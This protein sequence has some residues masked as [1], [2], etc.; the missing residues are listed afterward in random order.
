MKKKLNNFTEGSI[1][2]SIIKLSLPVVVSN[3]LQ[4]IYNLIDAFWLGRFSRGAVASISFSFPVLFLLISLGAGL[5][6]AGTILVS[7][8]F[9][10]GERE[11]VNYISTQVFLLV[12]LIS[13]I[14]SVSGIILSPYIL[15]LAGAKGDVFVGSVNYLKICFTGIIFIFGFFVFQSLLRGIGVVQL[16]MFI[17][18]GTV[19][20]N[21]FLDP[22]FILGWGDILEPMGVEGAAYA[23]V[24]SQGFAT[25]ILFYVLIK[26]IYGIK[27]KEEY[28]KL[29]FNLMKKIL[30]LGIPPAIEHSTRAFSFSILIF[31]VGKFGEIVVASYGIVIRIFGFIIIPAVGVAMAVTALVG[32]NMGAK[33]IKRAEK[34]SIMSGTFTFSFMLLLGTLFFLFSENLMEIFIPYDNSVI[35]FGSKFIK[36]VAFTFGFIGL[37]IV[38]GGTFRGAGNTKVAMF[39]TLSTFI[40]LRISLAYFFSFHTSL[41]EKGVWLA[42]GISNVVGGV[43][44]TVLFLTGFWK[45][46]RLTEEFDIKEE[47][48]REDI[49]PVI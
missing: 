4:T 35:E 44:A 41:K 31:I 17:V 26:G 19:I 24:I 18:L 29:N 47:L 11:K 37:Q 20:L 21:F 3:L 45:K 49:E 15:K 39:L 30:S 16:P 25:L 14:I 22:I 5:T 32:Q 1:F 40:I 10:K 12:I 38:F 7:Q 9:G 33:K 48:I 46:K 43:L 6:V 28:F 8:F 34:V 27:I 36:I 2:S 23:T 42:F 13:V